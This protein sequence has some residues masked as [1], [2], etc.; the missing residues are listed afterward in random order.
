MLYGYW[1]ILKKKL[2]NETIVFGIFLG[3]F[4]NHIKFLKNPKY[5]KKVGTEK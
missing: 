4:K 1:R 3:D 5:I 2:G